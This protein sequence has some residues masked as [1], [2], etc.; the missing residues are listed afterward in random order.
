MEERFSSLR[1]EKQNIFLFRERGER[2]RDRD[3]LSV[4]SVSVRHVLAYVTVCVPELKLVCVHV[5]T[6][7]IGQHQ[8]RSCLAF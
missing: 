6:E 2:G 3:Y 5:Q 1:K 4:S 7:A 8:I